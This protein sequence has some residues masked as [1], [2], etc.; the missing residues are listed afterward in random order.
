[1][2]GHGYGA[3]MTL[4]KSAAR[5]NL[6]CRRRRSGVAAL[7]P[8]I[9]VTDRR[10]LADPLAAA[11]RLPRGSAVLLRH[12]RDPDRARLAAALARLCR[13]RGLVLVVGADSRLAARAHAGG[14]HLP[15][16]LVARRR[17]RPR[18]G[19]L[20][21]A[22]A[23]GEAALVRAARAG[24]DACLL[25]PVFATASHPGARALGPVRFARLVRGAP[26]PVY[27][28]GGV[29]VRSARR[30]AAGGACGIAAVGAL[31]ARFSG[32]GAGAIRGVP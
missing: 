31:A 6:R 17:R 15:E 30:L 22:A 25:S 4:A 14:L 29:D 26:L 2:F 10:R 18:P 16:A 24:A 19:W 9:L 1:L 32:P 5:L 3:P 28:L 12:Y 8:L 20:V 21:T 7:P 11:A 23:H 27:A 13:R